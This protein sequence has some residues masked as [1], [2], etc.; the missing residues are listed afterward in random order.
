MIAELQEGFSIR[1][2]CQAFGVSESGY[3][4]WQKRPESDRDQE[5]RRLTKRIRELFQANW[6]VYGVPRIWKALREGGEQVNRKRVARL[7]RLAGLKGKQRRKRVRTTQRDDSHPV[8]DNK[9]SRQFSADRP[10][11]KWC[12]DITYI[13]TAHGW[14][15]LAVIIDLFSR[16]VVGWATSTSID[17]RLVELTWNNAIQHRLP[18]EELLCHSDRGSQYTSELYQ[19]ALRKLPTV[20]VSM[21]RKGNCWDN[22]VVESFFGSLKTE[23]GDCRHLNNEEA[24]LTLFEYIECFY[25]RKRLHSTLGYV[26]PV[27][28]EESYNTCLNSVSTKRG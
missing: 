12:G 5:N 26:S 19:S 23:V 24:H 16:K 8:V 2:L 11:Q 22:A 28:F 15:Y 7:M 14:L 27:Q 6:S 4:R 10:N 20:T 3:Y 25:N 17:A 9:L 18:S 21:S 1:R 13:R